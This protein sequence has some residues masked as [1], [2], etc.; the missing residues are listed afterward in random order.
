MGGKYTF[1]MTHPSKNIEATWS[2][3]SNPLILEEKV[4]G[5]PADDSIAL[6]S[7][8]CHERDHTHTTSGP[9]ATPCERERDENQHEDD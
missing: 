8:G 2:Q 9:Y 6:R 4:Q 7:T 1:K 3:T 5:R